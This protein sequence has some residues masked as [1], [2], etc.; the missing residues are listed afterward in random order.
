MIVNDEI[1]LKVRASEGNL[2]IQADMMDYKVQVNI[3]RPNLGDNLNELPRG[4]FPKKGYSSVCPF[5]EYQ[6]DNSINIFQTYKTYKK[7]SKKAKTESESYS[8]FKYTDKVRIVLGMINSAVDLG[9]LLEK[10]I[11]T[12]NYS[13]HQEK[14]I[15]YLKENWANF[16]QF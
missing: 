10:E 4:V 7:D 8:I 9:V 14:E 15:N 12:H 1:F 6:R 3:K 2:R 13:L 5:G 11:I 16:R